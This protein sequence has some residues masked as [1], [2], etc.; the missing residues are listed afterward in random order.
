MDSG[1]ALY[2]V[3]KLAGRAMVAA[4]APAGANMTAFSLGQI[5]VQYVGQVALSDG[6]DVV[7]TGQL[8]P[9]GIFSAYVI[10]VPA[11]GVAAS[12]VPAP[13]SEARG[14]GYFGLAFAVLFPALYTYW[15]GSH[16][17][18]PLGILLAAWVA[19][20]VVGYFSYKLLRHARF[21]QRFIDDVE[22]ARTLDPRM[23]D[24]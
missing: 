11:K 15:L 13:K 22:V 14:V 16:G 21:I 17:Y 19:G 8:V 9:G 5:P 1:L 12:R 6:D 24:R 10:D 4:G 23:V 18:W 20:A 3:E 7:V 2:K